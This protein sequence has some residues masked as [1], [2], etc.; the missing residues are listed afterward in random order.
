MLAEPLPAGSARRRPR[1][2]EGSDLATAEVL[3]MLSQDGRPEGTSRRGRVGRLS[4]PA[5][6]LDRGPRRESASIAVGAASPPHS[7]E[8]SLSTPEVGEIAVLALLALAGAL[9]LSLGTQ[10]FPVWVLNPNRAPSVVEKS[11]RLPAIVRSLITLLPLMVIA[12]FLASTG[13]FSGGASEPLSLPGIRPAAYARKEGETPNGWKIEGKKIIVWEQ[14]D[15]FGRPGF[16]WDDVP[17]TLIDEET[18]GRGRTVLQ[19][20]SAEAF[21]GHRLHGLRHWWLPWASS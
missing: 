5:A 4:H 15:A 10:L 9:G 11:R 1:P 12:Y 17:S 21:L 3:R 7:V 14:R 6:G 16:E 8:L 18:S 2:V 13:R 19:K 20:A